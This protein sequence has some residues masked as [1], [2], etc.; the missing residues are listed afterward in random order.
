MVIIWDSPQV[1]IQP[2]DVDTCMIYT[3]EFEIPVSHQPFYDHFRE[4]AK[5]I[6]FARTNVPPFFNGEAK[7]S[8]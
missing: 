4:L 8:L 7:N 5:Q 6:Q 1:T 3:S 2:V